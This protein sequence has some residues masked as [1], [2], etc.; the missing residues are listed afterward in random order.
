MMS[1]VR[2]FTHLFQDA[3]STV[4]CKLRNDDMVAYDELG[5]IW[6]ET[7]LPKL[8]YEASALT[9]RDELT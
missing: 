9:G 2:I 1:Y 8:G 6:K 7:I 5:W 4:R 3:V